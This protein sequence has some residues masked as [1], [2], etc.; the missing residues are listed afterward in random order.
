MK[1]GRLRTGY[2]KP[3]KTLTGC[4]QI[5]KQSSA[6][7]AITHNISEASVPVQAAPFICFLAATPCFQGA[8]LPPT[9]PLNKTQIKP[10]IKGEPSAGRICWQGSL[11][12]YLSSPLPLPWST[13]PLR[14]ALSGDEHQTHG[15]AQEEKILEFSAWKSELAPAEVV[16]LFHAASLEIR[17]G[18]FVNPESLW[19]SVSVSLEFP[20]PLHVLSI[21]LGKHWR[22][23]H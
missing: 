15:N 23:A 3:H 10:K 20:H 11:L 21:L 22:K 8:L 9:S 18:G 7:A 6:Q 1:R 19:S 4:W 13:L 14:N 5:Y 16:L 17:K 12:G 2:S